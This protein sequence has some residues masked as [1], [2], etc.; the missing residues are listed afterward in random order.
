MAAAVRNIPTL[1]KPSDPGVHEEVQ[2]FCFRKCSY[3][4]DPVSIRAL[5]V[6]SHAARTFFAD[7]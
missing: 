7:N 4:F 5:I 2:V 3:V 1:S 6:S